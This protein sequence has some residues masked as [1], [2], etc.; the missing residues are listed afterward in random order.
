MTKKQ[1]H[2]ARPLMAT[3]AYKVIV[4]EVENAGVS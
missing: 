3:N 1:C 4:F 2:D